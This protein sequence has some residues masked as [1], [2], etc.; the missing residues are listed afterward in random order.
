[1]EVNFEKRLTKQKVSKEILKIRFVAY[2]GIKL[3][4]T[5]LMKESM[6]SA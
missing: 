3:M 6:M 1:M 2:D 4:D 5:K